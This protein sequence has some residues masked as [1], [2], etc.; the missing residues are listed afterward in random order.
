MF[1]GLAGLA[2]AIVAAYVG[3]SEGKARLFYRSEPPGPITPD[4]MTSL[5]SP[6]PYACSAKATYA[7]ELYAAYHGFNSEDQDTATPHYYLTDGVPKDGEWW[8]Q[9][10]LGEAKYA[11]RGPI[12]CSQNPTNHGWASNFKILGST[13]YATACA[14]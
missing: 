1:I 13:N 9:V 5:T 4:N 10:D 2:Q 7:H 3:D 12:K 8:I 6:A 11:S 14:Q